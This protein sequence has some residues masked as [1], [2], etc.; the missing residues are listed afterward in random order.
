MPAYELIR[1]LTGKDKVV[2]KTDV[3]VDVK[4]E[5]SKNEVEI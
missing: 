4:I 2:A 1:T 5:E 3:A